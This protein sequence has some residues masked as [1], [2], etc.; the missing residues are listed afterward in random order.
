MFIGHLALSF[1]AKRAVPRVSLA[2]L[3]AAALLPDLVWPVLVGAGIEEVRI[4]PGNTAFTPLAFVSYPW[5]HSFLLVAVWAVGFALVHGTRTRHVRASPVLAALVVSHWVLDV[6]THRPDL[7]LYP[8]GPVYGLGLWN[9]VPATIAVEGA[10]FAVGALMYARC[11]RAAS[12]RGHWA[13][14]SLIGVLLVAYAAN[15]LSAPPSVTAIW[16]GSLVGGLLLVAWAAWT[17]RNRPPA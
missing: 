4:D 2:T 9:S 14:N 5:S 10:L 1:A 12:P 3:F 17:D 15:M 6:V 11:T 7:P 13:F 8:G 16:S